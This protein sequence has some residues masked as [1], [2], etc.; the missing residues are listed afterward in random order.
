MRTTLL[1]IAAI[2]AFAGTALGASPDKRTG[3]AISKQCAACHG[4]DGMSVDN[5]I[6]NLAGQHF[7]YLQEQMNA[8]KK[9]TRINPIMN[10]MISS[11]SQE[12]IDDIAAFYA[13]VHIRT[14]AAPQPKK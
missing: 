3:E 10:Q 7:V 14:E 5:N 12:Q 11:L 6:P 8:Y 4:N 13:S 1:A 9:R 2:V